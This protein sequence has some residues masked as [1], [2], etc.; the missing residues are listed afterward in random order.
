MRLLSLTEIAIITNMFLVL[1]DLV[2]HPVETL[3]LKVLHGGD[4]SD[5]LSNGGR[6]VSCL[7]GELLP[8]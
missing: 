5:G 8:S 2:H 3:A 6:L 7:L 4:H 1:Y